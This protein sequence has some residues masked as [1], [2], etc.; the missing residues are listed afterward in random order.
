MLPIWKER[1][2]GAVSLFG[3]I[4]CFLL[5]DP[6]TLIPNDNKVFYL[7][8]YGKEYVFSVFIIAHDYNS[9]KHFEA[10]PMS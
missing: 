6:Y 8:L 9:T 5:G 4:D 7:D 1:I 3:H 10:C 2:W